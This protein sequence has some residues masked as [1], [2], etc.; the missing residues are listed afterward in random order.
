MKHMIW[1]NSPDE[2]SAIAE[3]LRNENPDLSESAAWEEAA[4]T[5]SG[6]LDDELA[7]L[8]VPVG[9]ILVLGDLGLWNGRK[10]V[11]KVIR[12]KLSN[13]YD[14]TCGDYIDWYVEDGE[15]KIDDTHHDGTNHYLFRAWKDGVDETKK[16]LLL[17]LLS[18][19]FDDKKTL[20]VYTRPLGP[21]V[22]KVCG[23]EE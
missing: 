23:W 3:D 6:Y 7:A 9:E 1:S 14:V 19:G 21:D 15:M 22:A 13:A 18:N 11:F 8:A 20:D 2:I 10:K 5:N 4:D 12:S 16:G 17:H